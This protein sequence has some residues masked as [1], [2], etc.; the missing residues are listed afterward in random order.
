MGSVLYFYVMFFISSSW[1]YY[2]CTIYNNLTSAIM[3]QARILKELHPKEI[4]KQGR[5]L[6]FR[7]FMFSQSPTLFFAHRNDENTRNADHATAV[8]I[9]RK[10]AFVTY[11]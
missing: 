10:Y 5:T 2:D 8:L 6:F 7:P 3:K 1:S 11:Y 9:E 4:E